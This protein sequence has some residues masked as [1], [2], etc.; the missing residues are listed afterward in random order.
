MVLFVRHTL[1]HLFLWEVAFQLTKNNLRNKGNPFLIE[2]SSMHILFRG[3]F[4]KF[5]GDG[6]HKSS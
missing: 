2:E 1:A 3:G 6:G 5:D 4:C